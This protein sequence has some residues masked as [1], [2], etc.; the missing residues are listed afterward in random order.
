MAQPEPAGHL[1]HRCTFLLRSSDGDDLGTA[2]LIGA[3]QALTCAHVVEGLEEV[4]LFESVEAENP[5][6]QGTVG[7]RG[8]PNCIDDLALLNLDRTIADDGALTF[9]TWT[10]GEETTITG[11]P[12]EGELL[13]ARSTGREHRTARVTGPRFQWIEIESLG[14][15]RITEGFSGAAV[16]SAPRQVA[17]GLISQ[18]SDAALAFMVPKSEIDSFLSPSIDP[19]PLSLTCDLPNVDRRR[20]VRLVD[21]TAGHKVV[22]CGFRL[23]TRHVLTTRSVVNSHPELAVLD[24]NGSGFASCKVSDVLWPTKPADP[25]GVALVET[26]V[27]AWGP[28]FELPDVPELVAR[29]PWRSVAYPVDVSQPTGRRGL[30]G[31]VE[32]Q[33]V[34]LWKADCLEFGDGLDDAR[35]LL[36]S[37]IFLQTAGRSGASE[38][39]WT[40]AGVLDGQ[41][42]DGEWQFEV[43]T[44]ESLRRA[45]LVRSVERPEQ[46]RRVVSRVTR[47]LGTTNAQAA[48]VEQDRTGSWDQAARSPDNRLAVALCEQTPPVVLAQRCIGAYRQLVQAADFEGARRAYHILL[49]ALP[50]ALRSFWTLRMPE[51]Q[52]NE[53][54]LGLAGRFFVDF[55][56]AAAEDGPANFHRDD[57]EVPRRG[58]S[59][60]SSDLPWPRHQ[61]R[62]PVGELA[63]D[64]EVR[65]VGEEVAKDVVA[66]AAATAGPEDLGRLIGYWASERSGPDQTPWIDPAVKADMGAEPGSGALLRE[67]NEVLTAGTSDGRHFYFLVDPEENEDG[68][69]DRLASQLR[70]LLPELKIVQLDATEAQDPEY[71]QLR[72]DLLALFKKRRDTRGSNK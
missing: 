62:W 9:E 54:R 52:A 42:Q 15:R 68:R 65:D 11:F 28:R 33:G 56:L 37:A 24:P 66:Q 35:A 70:H 48:L 45:K 40:L 36:G 1:V 38:P 59:Q 34:G 25:G 49:E 17:I 6:A 14:K 53:V 71:R 18:C 50:A 10:P 58:A 19:A 44:L 3:S 31:M 7:R 69:L 27:A 26:E 20:W 63:F 32:G 2:V 60:S 64:P 8:R 43:H 51:A 21:P 72:R 29:H 61:V 41:F 57:T 13:G 5:I 55:V 47:L 46:P 16:W 23:S 67:I 4:Q 12:S 30:G 39:D 22:G